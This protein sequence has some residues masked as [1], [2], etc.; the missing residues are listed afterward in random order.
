VKKAFLASM[1]CLAG[2]AGLFAQQSNTVISAPL[3]PT[4]VPA[5]GT[6]ATTSG[7]PAKPKLKD[8]NLAEM[9]MDRAKMLKRIGEIDAKVNPVKE[10]LVGE[11]FGLL[12]EEYYALQFE[13]ENPDSGSRYFPKVRKVY[14]SSLEGA[15]MYFDEAYEALRQNELWHGK[16]EALIQKDV[17]LFALMEGEVAVAIAKLPNGEELTKMIAE[18][19]D[20]M[21]RLNQ[22][23]PLY[24]Y[25][26]E[27]RGWWRAY[28]NY[29]DNLKQESAEKLIQK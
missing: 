4:S 28:P 18:R 20:L 12:P 29:M 21:S 22:S 15:A 1:L 9:K 11:L 16:E 5:A 6:P 7:A 3:P 17:A 10:R 14:T 8:I 19:A 24:E 2:S 27:R 26:T 13:A 23:A 25:L